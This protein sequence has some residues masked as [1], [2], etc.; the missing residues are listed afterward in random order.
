MKPTKYSGRLISIVSMAWSQWFITC[1]GKKEKH[2]Q[3]KLRILINLIDKL[4][5]LLGCGTCA[6]SGISVPPRRDS[7]FDYHQ[8]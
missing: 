1:G 8:C 4:G 2:F 6:L 3:P 7:R 5:A